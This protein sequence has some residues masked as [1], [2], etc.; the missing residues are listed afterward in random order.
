MHINGGSVE[1]FSARV[2]HRREQEPLV[3][4]QTVGEEQHAALLGRG[5]LAPGLGDVLEGARRG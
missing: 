2:R 3:V 5:R 1:Q 4:R